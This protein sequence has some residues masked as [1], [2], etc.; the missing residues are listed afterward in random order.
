MVPAKKVEPQKQVSNDQWYSD[1]QTAKDVVGLSGCV[2]V[3]ESVTMG[4]NNSGTALVV[5]LKLTDVITGT[6]INYIG[7]SEKDMV[8]LLKL[9]G[10][11]MI[12][13]LNRKS[14]IVY[15][16][17]NVVKCISITRMLVGRDR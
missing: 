4:L 14:L 12:Y 11:Q 9:M 7:G 5:S 6:T 16:K 8:S 13:H 3:V 10:S 17:D 2:A 1:G 15:M